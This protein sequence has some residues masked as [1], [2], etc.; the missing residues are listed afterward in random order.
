MYLFWCLHL[1]TNSALEFNRD[2]GS[3]VAIRTFSVRQRSHFLVPHEY[4]AALDRISHLISNSVAEFFRDHTWLE[5][6]V[7]F[8]YFSLL[9]DCLWFVY[10]VL[11]LLSVHPM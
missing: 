5:R 7:A 8:E 10:L 3:E 6:A 11:K 2:S 9:N 1:E 4:G